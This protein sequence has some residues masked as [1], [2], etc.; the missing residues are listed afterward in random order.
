MGESLLDKAN[1]KKYLQAEGVI[2]K[3][4]VKKRTG[5]DLVKFTLKGDEYRIYSLF[6]S[7]PFSSG[8][9]IKFEYII[10]DGR[11]YNV[12]SILEVGNLHTEVTVDD[13][14]QL[15]KELGGYD[16]RTI[17]TILMRCSVDLCLK[18]NEIKDKEIFAC[19]ERFLSV[20]Q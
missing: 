4:D 10:K 17:K 11:Y 7:F 13:V 18:R 16:D 20:I 19:Y 3:I 2:F 14:S 9:S 6:G 12:T 8:D 5:D 1:K 15:K